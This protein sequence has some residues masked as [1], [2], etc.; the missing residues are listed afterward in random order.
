MV[1]LLQKPAD[2]DAI[3][4]A[5]RDGVVIGLERRLRAAAERAKRYVAKVR[6][7]PRAQGTAAETTRADAQTLLQRVVARSGHGVT[8]MIADDQAHYVAASGAT[9]AAHRL[10][11]E[12]ARRDVGLGFDVARQQR[13]RGRGSGSSSSRRARRKA[14]I[15][16][17]TATAARSK[18]ATLRWPTSPPAGISAPSPRRSTCRQPSAAADHSS[19]FSAKQRSRTTRP[20]MRC[21]WMMR[22]AFS[23]VTLLVPGPFRIHHA[24]RPGGADAQALAF[25]PV[26]RTVRAG[27]IQ[28]LQPLLQVAPGL[29]PLVGV[30]AVRPDADEQVPRQL[31]HAECFC[32]G[33]RAAHPSFCPCEMPPPCPGITARLRRLPAGIARES[34]LFPSSPPPSLGSRRFRL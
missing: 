22:S 20:P 24:D 13:R 4:A 11:R 14:A 28:L 21:S 7:R 19:G 5:I 23:G 3:L 33:V 31:S 32:D 6:R 9:R 15:C 26:A 12:R 10:R 1:S 18:R 27:Q 34:R 30:D 2:P 16:C 8:L 29:V 25:R 17:G